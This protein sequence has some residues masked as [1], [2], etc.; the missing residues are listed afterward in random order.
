LGQTAK[1]SA[2]V[3]HGS[4]PGDAWR[5]ATHEDLLAFF[6]A[7]PRGAIK[8]VLGRSGTGKSWLANA[9]EPH[10]PG[11]LLAAGGGAEDIYALHSALLTSGGLSAVGTSEIDR[12]NLLTVFIEHQRT[13]K[14]RV[15]I[16]IDD[17]HLLKPALWPEL[18]RLHALTFRGEPAAELIFLGQPGFHALLQRPGLTGFDSIHARVH[19]LGPLSDTEVASYVGHRLAAAG[20]PPN[21]FTRRAIKM[22]ARV[23]QGRFAVINTLCQLALVGWNPA[24]GGRVDIRRVDAALAAARAKA[25]RCKQALLPPEPVPEPARPAAGELVISRGGNLSQRC[26]LGPRILIGRGS[27]N[28]VSLDDGYLSRYHAAIIQTGAGYYIVDL[29]SANGFTVNAEFTRAALLKDQDVVGIG[30]YRMKFLEPAKT[31]P[32]PA[33]ELADTAI[34]TGEA[35][36]KPELRQVK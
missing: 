20:L 19:M 4:K 30:P 9:Y 34:M 24:S 3:F 31:A 23:A 25:N 14:R 21:L 28:D 8:V 17:A 15:Q 12:R 18:C 36:A 27:H 10:C 35:D 22:V 1:T 2:T 6:S 7:Q 33:A 13:Q 32:D 5:G 11:I 26:P 16:I 29:N